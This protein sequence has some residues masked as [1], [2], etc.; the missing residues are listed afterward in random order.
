L[1]E[2]NSDVTGLYSFFGSMEYQ[3]RK[4][5]TSASVSYTLPRRQQPH[6]PL[7]NTLSSNVAR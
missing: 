7:I 3:A 5:T 1:S 4:N 6:L 2:S